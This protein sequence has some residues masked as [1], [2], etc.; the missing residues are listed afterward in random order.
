MVR[1]FFGIQM[2]YRRSASVQG[3]HFFTFVCS[4]YFGNG[5]S[6]PNISG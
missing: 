2:Y 3:Q 6:D 1:G 5:L 4:R